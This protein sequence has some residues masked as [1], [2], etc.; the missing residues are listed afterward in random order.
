MSDVLIVLGVALA[1]ALCAIAVATGGA[2]R[3]FEPA[4]STASV[5]QGIQAAPLADASGNLPWPK[6]G[7]LAIQ[8]ALCA[9]LPRRDR[10]N[11]SGAGRRRSQRDFLVR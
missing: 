10:P 6:R 9:V 1:A 2:I 7:A 4:S 5:P 8:H 3:P 11:A